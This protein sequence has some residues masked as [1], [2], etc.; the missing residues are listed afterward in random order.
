MFGGI[1][2]LGEGELAGG[3]GT[4]AKRLSDGGYATV[5]GLA[6]PDAQCPLGAGMRNGDAGCPRRR[7][8]EQSARFRRREED[9]EEE[10][11]I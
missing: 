5:R 10:R 3:A 4:Y 7:E 9:R 11:K 6:D 8:E 1:G 2:M